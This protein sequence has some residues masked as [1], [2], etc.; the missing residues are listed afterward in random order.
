MSGQ[1]TSNVEMGKPL[2]YLNK[3]VEDITQHPRIS[4]RI[5]FQKLPQFC[6][7]L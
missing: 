7:P 4:N 5:S 6:L 1:K 3:F 2:N